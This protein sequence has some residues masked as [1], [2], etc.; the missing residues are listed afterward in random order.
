MDSCSETIGGEFF[1]TLRTADPGEATVPAVDEGSPRAAEAAVVREELGVARATLEVATKELA[2][3]QRSRSWKV[4]QPL[5]KFN[6]MR[7]RRSARRS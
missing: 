6:E 2:A 7:A 4:T 1:A 3:M 5:R